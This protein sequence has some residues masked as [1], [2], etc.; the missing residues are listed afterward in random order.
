MFVLVENSVKV[1]AKY[2]VE[3]WSYCVSVS[4]NCRF[5]RCITML[6]AIGV[7]YD[8]I[9][10]FRKRRGN[11]FRFVLTPW[12]LCMCTFYSISSIKRQFIRVHILELFLIH[13]TNIRLSLHTRV[14]CAYSSYSWY[15]TENIDWKT[16]IFVLFTFESYWKFMSFHMES[17]WQGQTQTKRW[18]DFHEFSGRRVLAFYVLPLLAARSRDTTIIRIIWKCVNTE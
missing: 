10:R 9:D 13:S 4:F 11:P 17:M 1:W 5:S 15:P 7:T 12:T 16:K 8:K 14:Y 6:L 18:I 2:L 3:F